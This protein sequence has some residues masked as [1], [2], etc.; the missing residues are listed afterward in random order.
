MFTTVKMEHWN[1]TSIFPCEISHSHSMYKGGVGR[2]RRKGVWIVDWKKERFL[3]HKDYSPPP[4]PPPTEVPANNNN[5]VGEVA[6]LPN[7]FCSFTMGS[8]KTNIR[9]NSTTQHLQTYQHP[10]TKI[11]PEI[12]SDIRLD[13]ITILDYKLRT[14]TLYRTV[15]ENTR[16]RN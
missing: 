1:Q 6:M 12:T 4:P 16:I 8:V 3:L 7:R 15:L 11:R 2:W 10:S 14:K 5:C 13:K 9:I